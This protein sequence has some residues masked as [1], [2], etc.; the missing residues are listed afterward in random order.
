MSSDEYEGAV[1]HYDWMG[2]YLRSQ[3]DEP[4][5]RVLATSRDTAM[6]R[7]AEEAEVENEGWE[8]NS[9]TDHACWQLHD[10]MHHIVTVRRVPVYGE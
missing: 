3:Y 6:K 4:S 8:E 5:G 7:A 10:T 9:L 1:D 2:Y